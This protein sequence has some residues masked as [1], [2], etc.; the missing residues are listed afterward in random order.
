MSI[1]Q[2]YSEVAYL[3][4]TYPETHPAVLEA[5]ARLNGLTPPSA[6]SARVLVVGCGT[7]ANAIAI[8]D[9]LPEAEVIGFDLVESQIEF[10]RD[11]NRHAGAE[12]CRLE[13]ADLT[14]LPT[15]FGDFDYIV[16]HGIYSWV[17]APVREGLLALIGERLRSNGVALVSYNL[18]PGCAF[19]QPAMD[20]MRRF[21][22]E[23]ASPVE[24]VLK[25]RQMLLQYARLVDKDMPWGREVERLW[26]LLEE[27]P[28][29]YIIHDFLAEINEP[30]WFDEFIDHAAE[31]DLHYAGESSFSCHF[32]GKFSLDE[33]NALDCLGSDRVSCEVAAD[34]IL[35]RGFRS[36]LLSKKAADFDVTASRL[37]GLF[38]GGEVEPAE[39]E[40]QDSPEASRFKGKAGEITLEEEEVSRVLTQLW[41]DRPADLAFDDLVA[42]ADA[43]HVGTA[44]LTLISRNMCRMRT[45]PAPCVKEVSECPKVS[46]LVR[47]LAE[48]GNGWVP[49]RRCESVPVDAEQRE[50]LAQ[51]DGTRSHADLTIDGSVEDVLAGVCSAGLLIA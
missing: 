23:A 28:E 8:A 25:V 11:L 14:Q 15:E 5:V 19:E 9:T 33:Q 30:F 13:V 42:Q 46:P 16:A 3:T 34:A 31:H 26:E 48:L 32:G 1:E 10:A 6:A 29:S 21:A 37:A 39:S 27:V 4:K 22:A 24:G 17:P 20:I 12:N 40:D 51:L 49:N 44:L 7:G 35:G 36:T 18:Q 47:R 41:N 50:L 45:L 43:E 2:T 38:V